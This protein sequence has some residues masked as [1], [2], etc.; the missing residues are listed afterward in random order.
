[1]KYGLPIIIAR[2]TQGL[3]LCATMLLPPT[4]LAADPP[5]LAD[6]ARQSARANGLVQAG[7]AEQA[8]PIYKGL[9]AAFPAEPSFQVNL[10]VA[11]YK[12]A[13][14]RETIDAC[15][16][17][18]KRQPDL[19]PAWLFL[20]ASHLKL[21]AAADAEAA[22]RKAVALQPN[23]ANARLMLADALLATGRWA[24]A[25]EHYLAATQAIPDSP[26]AWYGLGRS[27]AALADELFSHLQNAAPG[28][29]ED[30]A[31]S[32][33]SGFD[34]GQLTRAFQNCR[35]A[36]ALQPSFRGLHDLIA[37]IYEGTG[38]AEWAQA[39]RAK[40][41][42]D[43]ESCTNRSPECDFAAARFREAAAAE[44]NSPDSLYWRTKALLSLSKQA[45]QRLK[46]LAPS[47]ESF[48]AT[49][50][51]EEKRGR[52]P[53][54]AEA[55]KEALRWEP[56]DLQLQRQLALALCHA[57]DCLS[58]LP[59]LKGQLVSMPESAD[60]NYLYGLALNSTQNPREARSYLEKAVRLN[61]AFLPARAALG[62]AYLKCGEA[63][64]AISQLKAAAAD[65]D[66]GTRHYQL[67][68]AYQ[69]AGKRAEA[70]ST[71]RE[72]RE[73][74]GRRAAEQQNEEPITPP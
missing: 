7:K 29:A 33:E 44:T 66:N 62:E 12:A 74:V 28:S 1:M 54:A 5:S 47:K 9:A 3:A 36:L 15:H 59:L 13:R 43:G 50:A 68:Q 61:S 64:L 71:L 49:A 56:S 20:G 53:E 46:T 26:R 48:E 73:I 6:A 32:A 27:Y 24:D 35:Q 72:Y 60:L 55:W 19:F 69:A 65:D 67:A 31:L 22:L 21:G 11:L 14:Y 25:A 4:W 8:V 39:E 40:T 38:H 42:H 51:A 58:A 45:Y 16:A 70:V 63:E 37:E 41:Q 34:R 2:M 23:D 17:L 18:L 57:N 52:Y 10:A 30:L